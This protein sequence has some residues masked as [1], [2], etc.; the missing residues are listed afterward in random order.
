MKKLY[1]LN[2]LTATGIIAVI[3]SQTQKEAIKTSTACINGGIKGIEITFTT[4]GADNVIRELT[5]IYQKH[6][7]IIGAG[8]VLDNITARIAILAG[9]KFIVSPFYDQNIAK[10][11]NLYQT[12]YIPGCLTIKEIKQA[13]E[14]GV[15]IIKLFPGG[16]VQPSFIKKLKEPLPQ[17]N[18]IPTG[19]INLEN[20]GK[21]LKSGAIAVGVGE[22]LTFP[23]KKGK[24]NEVSK[25]AQKFIEHIKKAKE[26]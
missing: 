26:E 20:V 3:R 9:A 19:G 4:P 17:V 23:A 25:Y 6:N 22:S 7:I 2:T 16:T 11:C 21:W 13:L 24:Y 18:I 1:V 10:L 15:D 12:P 8:T 14:S 5:S